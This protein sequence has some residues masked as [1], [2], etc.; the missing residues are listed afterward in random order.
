[1]CDCK[2]R[3][4]EAEPYHWEPAGAN[5]ETVGPDGKDQDLRIKNPS[6]FN[7]YLTEIVSKLSALQMFGWA[8]K[9]T[10]MPAGVFE[11]LKKATAL[12]ALHLDLTVERNNVHARKYRSDKV[13]VPVVD[14]L[15]EHPQCPFGSW[16]QDS[17]R[18]TFTPFMASLTAS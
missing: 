15:S 16:P 17:L 8:C 9:V 3:K 7:S 18:S 14:T 6:D 2:N 11:A 13:S 10:P 12:T 4:G 5:V 1:M